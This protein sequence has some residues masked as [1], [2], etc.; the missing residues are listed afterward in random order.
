MQQTEELSELRLETYDTRT[1]YCRALGHELNFSYC[2]R[3]GTELFCK[4]IFDCWHRKIDIFAYIE[5]FFSPE[6]IQLVLKPSAP[7]T[8]TLITLIDKAKNKE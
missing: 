1:I 8:N 4:K 2:R 5:R 7:K 6:D 3:T